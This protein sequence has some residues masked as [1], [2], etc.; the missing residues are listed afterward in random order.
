MLVGQRSAQK[1]CHFGRYSQFAIVY[2][3]YSILCHHLN[4][5]SHFILNLTKYIIKIKTT[6]RIING[7]REKRTLLENCCCCCK[8]VIWWG[9][10]KK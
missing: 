3:F 10:K 7:Q 4:I 8:N 9:L 5:N 6:A 2:K 1:I